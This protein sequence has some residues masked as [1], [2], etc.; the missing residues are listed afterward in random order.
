MYQSIPPDSA[1]I[2]H[3]RPPY[4][5]IC[6]AGTIWPPVLSYKLYQRNE[7]HLIMEELVRPT[8]CSDLTYRYYPPHALI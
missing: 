4:L 5:I 7:G 8:K 3:D 1:V 2:N 6:M